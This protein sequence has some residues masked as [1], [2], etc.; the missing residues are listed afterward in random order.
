MR[1]AARLPRDATLARPLT[2][3]CPGRPTLAVVVRLTN[4]TTSQISPPTASVRARTSPFRYGVGMFGTSIPINL[5]KG[6][7][8][9]F[10]TELLGM[11][12]AVFATVYG[13]YSVIDAVDNPVIGFLSDRTRTRWGRR[14]PYLVVGAL[15]LLFA[16]IA[17]FA[18]P[19]SVTSNATLL[20]VWFATFTI[21]AEISDSVVNANYGALLPELF[22]AE[23]VRAKANAIRQIGQ[24]LA[25]ILALGLTPILARNVLGCDISDPMCTDPT[26]GY[27]RLAV[28]F[29][30][31]G[32]GVILYM[33]FGVHEN[34]QIE[35]E[36]RPAFWA[37]VRQILGTSYFWTIG[38]VNACYGAAMALVLNGLQLFVQ[39]SLKGT[40][41]DATILQVVVIISA[42]GLVAAWAQLV[43]RWGA[44]R[45]WKLALPIA[46]VAFGTMF[47]A[48]DLW[49][50]IAAGIAVAVGYAGVLA[51]NDLIMARV[52]D[53]D[54]RRHKVHREAVFLAAFGVLGR[55]N[56]VI[57]A[58]ALWSLTQ[59]FGYRSGLEP[60]DNP[61]LAF[62]FYLSVYPVILLTIGTIISRFVHVPGWDPGR[63]KDGAA[64]G[65]T[66]GADGVADDVEDG[67]ADD[68]VGGGSDGRGTGAPA[69]STLEQ[70]ANLEGDLEDRS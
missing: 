4:V 19:S 23:K 27:E 9:Y 6:S 55:L 58:I 59:F 60:G 30:V 14:K 65:V 26:I 12:A 25:M 42:I 21:L 29:A 32:V 37:T 53:E 10:Y 34:P 51:T 52:L 3:G 45:T 56:G 11:D 39:Y 69:A 13:V 28:I 46:A 31:L 63:A 17:I 43:R 67:G 35:E 38:V 48:Q 44:E 24:L 61:D 15:A 70:V 18:I 66:G 2:A 16:S 47:F 20:V 40:A 5:I 57:V 68:V 22:P 49:S 7:M 33:A 54:A 64:D 41:L 8:L 1:L 62:R 36:R 50:A